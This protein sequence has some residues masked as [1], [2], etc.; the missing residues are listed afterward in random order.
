MSLISSKD[1]DWMPGESEDQTPAFLELKYEDYQVKSLQS[2]GVLPSPN[3]VKINNVPH[4]PC[5]Y[6]EVVSHLIEFLLKTSEEPS[7]DMY[8]KLIQIPDI[9]P[10]STVQPGLG[11][12][13]EEQKDSDANASALT[14]Y[15]PPR[16]DPTQP[17]QDS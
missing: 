14:N 5:T 8:P 16:P 12:K 11:N 15:C 10:H 9:N 17:L 7:N 13:V 4:D 2:V 6:A 1:P 3:Q